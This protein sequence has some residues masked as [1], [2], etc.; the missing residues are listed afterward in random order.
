MRFP[1][2]KLLQVDKIDKW[3]WNLETSHVY[4]VRSAY[5]LLTSQPPTASVVSVSS[6]WNK[7]YPLKVVLF[8][9]RL[10]RDRLPSKN[11]LFRRGVISNDALL[12]A[13]GCGI[14]ETS[15]HLFL[16]CNIFGSIWHHI[17]KWLNVSLV[18]PSTVGDHF[19]QFTALGG[20]AKARQSILQVIWFATTWEI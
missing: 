3:L 1:F 16:H 7:D 9:W 14:E 19:I 11:N 12:C 5:K 8:A 2:S 13:T 17:F 4:S 10:F 18:I 15:E 6:L 20:I